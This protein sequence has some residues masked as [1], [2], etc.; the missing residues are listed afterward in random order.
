MCG[1]RASNARYVERKDRGSR[2]TK[3]SRALTITPKKLWD[4]DE[5]TSGTS[6]K[7]SPGYRRSDDPEKSTP[8]S[9]LRKSI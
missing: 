8:L 7:I 4:I 9:V 5:E 2:E 1:Q 6:V 3:K